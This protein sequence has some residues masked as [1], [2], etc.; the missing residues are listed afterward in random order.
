MKKYPFGD[1]VETIGLS[2]LV[3]FPHVVPGI[4]TGPLPSPLVVAF[5]QGD[6]H[7]S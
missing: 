3:D 2:S 1:L 5:T 6:T 7:M 4:R